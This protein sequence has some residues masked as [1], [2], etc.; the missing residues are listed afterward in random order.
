MEVKQP[1]IMGFRQQGTVPLNRSVALGNM[2]IQDEQDK[3]D[4]TL[5]HRKRTRSMIG[6]AF[7]D[8]DELGSRKFGILV[9]ERARV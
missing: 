4:E 1:K 2:D 3:E 7:E 5:R 8:L 9:K 6:W